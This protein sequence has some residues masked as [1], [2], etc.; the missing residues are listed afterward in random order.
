MEIW[1]QDTM[2][3]TQ[4]LYNTT[5]VKTKLAH[6]VFLSMSAKSQ[7]AA[8]CVTG[9][10]ISTRGDFNVHHQFWLSSPFTDYLGELAFNFAIL[11]DLDQATDATTPYLQS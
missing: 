5:R 11:H 9:C 1:R 6:L 7:S 8:I 4:T 10:V 2:S 3:P